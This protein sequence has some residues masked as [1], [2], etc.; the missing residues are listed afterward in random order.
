VSAS[1]TE[2]IIIA[3]LTDH[4]EGAHGYMYKDRDSKTN[5]DRQSV[6]VRIRHGTFH[7]DHAPLR[8]STIHKCVSESNYNTRQSYEKARGRWDQFQALG[9][10]CGT[11]GGGG[12]SGA[13]GC[14]GIH[15]GGDAEADVDANADDSPA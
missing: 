15:V 9:M 11:D 13:G 1:Y 8:T 12:P 10:P 2:E 7:M 4:P 14:C 6:A 3:S 5:D